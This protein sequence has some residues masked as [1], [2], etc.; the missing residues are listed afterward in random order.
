MEKANKKQDIDGELK[1]L[2]FANQLEAEREIIQA[3]RARLN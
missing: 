3:R 2:D 1:A